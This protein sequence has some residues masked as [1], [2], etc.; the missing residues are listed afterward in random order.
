L[1][2]SSTRCLMTESNSFNVRAGLRVFAIAEAAFIRLG[3]ICSGRAGSFPHMFPPN[4]ITSFDSSKNKSSTAHPSALAILIAMSTLGICT[5]RSIS[6]S[7]D[8]PILTDS[9]RSF[10]V[11]PKSRRFFLTLFGIINNP[12]RIYICQ[13]FMEECRYVDIYRPQNS[14]LRDRSI[15]LKKYKN[16]QNKGG[17][18]MRKT[19]C[20]MASSIFLLLLV[21]CSSSGSKTSDLGI[22]SPESSEPAK[23]AEFKDSSENEKQDSAKKDDDLSA[24]L[25]DFMFNNF[26]GAGNPEFATSWYANIKDLSVYSSGSAYYAVAVVD[27]TDDTKVSRIGNSIIVNFDDVSLSYIMVVDDLGTVLFEKNA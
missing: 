6:L 23:T 2:T 8:L 4:Y 22:S 5:P 19:F 9:A 21:S 25:A 16:Q 15:K 1:S 14:I 27:T 3:R 24:S 12:L 17:M 11:I 13:Q 18:L 10:C 20:I 26:G 7:V